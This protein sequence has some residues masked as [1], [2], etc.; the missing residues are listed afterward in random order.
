MDKYY[1]QGG[2][3][4][5]GKLKIS[6]A[7]NAVLP[8]LAGAILC[9]G[10]VKIN[11]YPQYLDTQ[12]MI[13]VLRH[14]GATVIENKNSLILDMTNLKRCDVPS[15]LAVL[16]RSSFFCL[17]AILGRFKKAKISYPGGCEI[18]LRPID[19]HLK[20]LEKLGVKITDKHGYITCNGGNM[21]GNV[22]H[23]DFAS[24]GA[25]ENLI[26]ASV[27]GSGETIITNAAKEP[28]IVDLQNFL[29]SA[30]AKIFGAGTG[31]I[32][33]VGV[34]K[35]SN[36]EYTPISDRI[37][38]GTYM[39]ATA[40]CGG[41]IELQTQN[42][43]HLDALVCKLREIGCKIECFYDKILFES[44]SSHKAISKIETLPY[45]GFP[46]DLQSQMLALLATCQG[47]SVMIENLFETRFK[48]VGELLKMGANVL[49]QDRCAIV[50][51][52][53]KLYGAEVNAT[54]LRG[55]AGLV[56]AALMVEGYT[57]ISYIEQI[58]RGYEHIDEDLASLGANIKRINE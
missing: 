26:M 29:N 7:K 11:N 4:L 15:D 44:N 34:D 43:F 55:G 23:L 10:V 8:I 35:L 9:D 12:N 46:T 51:G 54:D 1:I 49:I 19:L 56:L 16:T 33:I 27:L 39:I 30:G 50:K 32:K 18:G 52:V 40:I 36:V 58:N 57:K 24:V 45:P 3:K 53:E 25:T 31:I 5:E 48:F 38:T 20:G 6:A 13:K 2:Q 21:K 42:A 47:T 37:I 17:G 28:E 22:I 14:L 41:N